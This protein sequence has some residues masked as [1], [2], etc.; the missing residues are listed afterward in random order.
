MNIHSSQVGP[1][2]YCAGMLPLCP[3]SMTLIEGG[4]HAE[5]VLC[6]RSIER[7]LQAMDASLRI[8]D[9]VSAVCFVTES[10]YISVAKED[11]SATLRENRVMFCL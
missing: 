10:K 8:R 2:F 11:L 1:S 4:I 3:S 7:V 6:F 5:N 9:I